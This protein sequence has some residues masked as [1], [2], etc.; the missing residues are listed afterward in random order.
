MPHAAITREEIHTHQVVEE[1]KRP[2]DG[3]VSVFE[4]IVRNHSRGRRA[5]YLDYEAYEEMALEQMEA[6]AQKAIKD[7]KI[8]DAKL[9]HRLGC[10]FKLAKTQR[11]D[12]SGL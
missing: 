7:F 8:R 12:R 2:S 9:I 1:I 10:V 4:G 11:V 6:L 5:L 3:A